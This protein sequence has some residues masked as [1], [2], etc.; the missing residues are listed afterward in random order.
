MKRLYPALFAIIAIVLVTSSCKK[1]KSDPDVIPDP[2]KILVM[3][4]DDATWI[5]DVK[6][7]IDST[8]L[9]TIVDTFDL[10]RRVP[11][12][13]LLAEYD[14]L[15]VYTNDSPKDAVST[16]DTLVAYINQGGGVVTATF[17][18]NIPISGAF[19]QYALLTETSQTSTPSYMD[20][21][22]DVNHPILKSVLTFDGGTS[23]YRN[24]GGVI[25]D[26]A[27][28]VAKWE[29][30]EPLIIVKENVGTKNVNMVFL[31]FFPPS[32]TMRDDF[33]DVSTDGD[34]LMAG[35]LLWVSTK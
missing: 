13:T 25:S 35:A 33:W 1:D 27:T 32:N 24:N 34:L 18:G 17:A 21:I 22:L 11:T 6:N 20:V 10:S 3:G 31:N 28:I 12:L 7:K 8:D 5:V 23:S 26:G 19:E 4:A 30:G 15:I 16:G 2:P 29:D 9:F 14:A